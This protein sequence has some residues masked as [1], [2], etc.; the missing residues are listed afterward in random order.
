MLSLA[1]LLKIH[2][3]ASADQG[4]SESSLLVFIRKCFSLESFQFPKIINIHRYLLLHGSLVVEVLHL[5]ALGGADNYQ[6][7]V[8]GTFLGF[9][10]AHLSQSWT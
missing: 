2:E 7:T 10:S 6:V 1:R 9:V 8:G 3:L 4:S 5:L